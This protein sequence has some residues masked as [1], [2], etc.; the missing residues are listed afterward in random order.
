M[1]TGARGKQPLT[2]RRHRRARRL[3]PHELAREIDDAPT[4]AHPGLRPKESLR[5]DGKEACA[6]GP[7]IVPLAPKRGPD[8]DCSDGHLAQASLPV[9]FRPSPVGF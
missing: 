8:L 1:S 6:M 2:P 9:L 4:L 7:G 3:L 5:K